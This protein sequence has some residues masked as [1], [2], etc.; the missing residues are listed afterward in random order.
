[1][2]GCENLVEDIG[3]PVDNVRKYNS[4]IGS[5]CDGTLYEGLAKGATRAVCIGVGIVTKCPTRTHRPD[6][7]LATSGS[8]SGKRDHPVAEITPTS[9]CPSTYI[10]TISSSLAT[11]TS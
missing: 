10:P 6:M 7:C 8:K 5:D 1:M 2:S 11:G 4:W 9:E 3:L